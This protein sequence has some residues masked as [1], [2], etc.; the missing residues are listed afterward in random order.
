[1][2]I[3]VGYRFKSL[4]GTRFRIWVPQRLKDYLIKGYAIN[5]QRLEQS[6]FG[7]PFHT[8]WKLPGGATGCVSQQY[9]RLLSVRFRVIIS[10]KGA[11][12][13]SEPV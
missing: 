7:E 8:P 6:V 9:L 10:Q 4:Q 12:L 13:C 1:V 3:P 5:H 2:I 11:M